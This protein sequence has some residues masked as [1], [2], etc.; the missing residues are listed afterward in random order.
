MKF[1][2]EYCQFYK[3]E[4]PKIIELGIYSQDENGNKL[5]GNLKAYQCKKC[6]EKHEKAVKKDDNDVEC[7]I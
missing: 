6:T 1:L 3:D 7:R 2:C 4:E 5:E